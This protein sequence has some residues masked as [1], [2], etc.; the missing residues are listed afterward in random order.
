MVSMK[1]SKFTGFI[2]LAVSAKL[3][4]TVYVFVSLGRG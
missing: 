1:L 4:G 3:V 2:M